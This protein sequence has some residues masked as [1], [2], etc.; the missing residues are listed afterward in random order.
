LGLVASAPR[1]PLK[2][3]LS[4]LEELSC[5]VLEAPV[6]RATA[7]TMSWERTVGSGE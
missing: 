7:S 2:V 1:L 4:Q 6:S 3:G 5:S